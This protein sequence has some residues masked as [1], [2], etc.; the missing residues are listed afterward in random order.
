MYFAFTGYLPIYLSD[1]SH[2][3]C[4]TIGALHRYAWVPCKISISIIS[5][6]VDGLA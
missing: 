5:I 3:C 6:L 2:A 1:Q 4:I